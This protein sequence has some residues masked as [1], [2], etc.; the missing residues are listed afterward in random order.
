[1]LRI[2]RRPDK[3]I[4][5]EL[6]H[7]MFSAIVYMWKEAYQKKRRRSLIIKN[8]SIAAIT[9]VFLS[10]NYFF[11][12]PYIKE[13][14]T[15]IRPL[16]N[17]FDALKAG[18]TAARE[19]TNLLANA[20]ANAPGSSRVA[21]IETQYRI[22]NLD[23]MKKQSGGEMPPIKTTQLRSVP[24]NNEAGFLSEDKARSMLTEKGF[25]DLARNK[26]AQG[27]QN[28]FESQSAGKIVYDKA[29][30]LGWQLSGSDNSLTF[31][32]AMKYIDQLNHDKFAEM[33]IH[34][35][36]PSF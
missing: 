4:W 27:F 3:S 29:T 15:V 1:M 32:E 5:F 12:Y 36:P 23:Y 13:T 7:D 34:F 35:T 16:Q 20:K 10:V 22:W 31:D 2:T 21:H 14:L 26:S 24:I 6:Y 17:G 18:K 9:A 8:S 11:T 28:D 19:F 30:S 25:F 33:G